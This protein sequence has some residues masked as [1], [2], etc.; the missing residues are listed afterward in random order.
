MGQVP[1][2][3]P[4]F[5]FNQTTD[6]AP[7]SPFNASL[8]DAV[9]SGAVTASASAS[10]VS[11]IDLANGLNFSASGSVLGSSSDANST[12]TSSSRFSLTFVVDMPTPYLFNEQVTSG[13]EI[14]LGL[15]GADLTSDGQSLFGVSIPGLPRLQ[16][17][18][19]P[20]FQTTGILAPGTYTLNGGTAGNGNLT[21]VDASYTVNFST[22]AVS[23]TSQVI[24]LPNGCWN[25]A[26]GLAF[27][28][29]ALRRI[30]KRQ[31]RF[32]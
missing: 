28:V 4:A 3:G 7:G 21:A 25:G 16:A 19:V 5:S 23:T 11:T 15:L 10:E 9:G 8:Q 24:P 12:F 30:R 14:D 6:A 27:S 18:D 20:S 32:I 22:S 17:A 29:L 13:D 26:I 1:G 31:T 2:A